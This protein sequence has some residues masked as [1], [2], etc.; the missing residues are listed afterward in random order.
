MFSPDETSNPF[1]CVWGVTRWGKVLEGGFP[2]DSSPST[3]VFFG[4]SD[5][6]SWIC[7]AIIRFISRSPQRVSPV[8]RL[9]KPQLTASVCFFFR[10]LWSNG[11]LFARGGVTKQDSSLVI[12]TLACC[13]GHKPASLNLTHVLMGRGA[14]IASTQ[15]KW[16]GEKVSRHFADFGCFCSVWLVS[17]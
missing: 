11:I 4:H 10:S 5:L 13:Q 16:R 7:W 9:Q 8:Q 2:T 17:K 1:G 6:W 14:R 12:A 3:C 15:G